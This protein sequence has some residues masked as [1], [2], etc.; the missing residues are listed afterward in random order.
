MKTYNKA[1][2]ILSDN[3]VQIIMGEGEPFDY[4]VQTAVA[5]VSDVELP[6]NTVKQVMQ[7]GYMYKGKVLRPASVIV[8]N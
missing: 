7:A 3:N 4:N 2:Q 6:D 1:L 5:H 8:A